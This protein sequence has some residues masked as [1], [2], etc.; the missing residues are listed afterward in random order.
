MKTCLRPAYWVLDL[1]VGVMVVL[2][3]TAIGFTGVAWHQPIEFAWIALLASGLR[4]W[5]VVNRPALTAEA[6]RLNERWRGS[7]EQ[8]RFDAIYGDDEV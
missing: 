4:L 7:P 2:L 3:F 8:W 1:F 5:I 6:T